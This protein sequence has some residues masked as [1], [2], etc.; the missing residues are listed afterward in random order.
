MGFDKNEI[1]G[2]AKRIGTYETS[3]GPE[4][5][6]TL[7]PAH[8]ATSSTLTQVLQEEAKLDVAAL[9]AN[10]LRKAHDVVLEL[11]AAPALAAAKC[12]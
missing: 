2:V 6:D 10:A 1:I 4:L 9:V 8:P 5:C 11:D 7:G 12:E 3:C